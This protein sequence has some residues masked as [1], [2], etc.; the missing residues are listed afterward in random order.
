[1]LPHELLN[2][3]IVSFV[4]PCLNEART[5]KQC[6]H[7]CC[8]AIND[9][10]LPAEIIVSDNGSSDDSVIIAKEL[11]VR[12]V[13]IENRGYGATIRGGIL[14]AR[15]KFVIMGD[16]DASYDL[17]EISAFISR[18]N[19]GDDLVVGNRLCGHIEPGAMPWMNRYIGNPFL[20]G[21][22][23]FLFDSGLGDAHCGLRAFRRSRI[24]ELG[25]SS[26]GMELASEMI[27]KARLNALKISEVPIK[28]YCDA[29][30]RR[31]HL[32]PFR[33]AIRHVS[34]L[35]TSDCVLEGREFSYD[36]E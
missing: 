16:S 10:Q 12:I 21:L 32:R 6:I 11:N 9:L 19:H 29:R 5:L 22:L 4:L 26:D 2:P 36:K 15:G 14:A 20:T 28:F 24:L 30:G 7:M 34:V 18:L 27:V 31:P 17:S 13:S 33:D 25:L 35:L 1:M 3:I 8:R 23:N